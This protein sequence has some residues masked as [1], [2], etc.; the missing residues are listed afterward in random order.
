MNILN[1][2]YSDL[3]K[4]DTFEERFEYLK[5][6]G[7]VGVETFGFNRFINQEFYRSSKWRSVRREVILRDQGYDLGV[8]GYEIHIDLLVHHM[9]PMRDKDILNEE[10]WIYDPEYL[11]TTSKD[12]HNAIHYGDISLIKTPFVER[13]P[14]D[15]KLW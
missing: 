12:T 1:R 9:T 10:P 11:I 8:P 7:S 3:V 4:L 15:T 6:G 13:K 2:C 14:G 5:L